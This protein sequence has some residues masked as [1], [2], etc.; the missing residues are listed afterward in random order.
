MGDD[1]Q[2]SQ[3]PTSKLSRAESATS[4]RSEMPEAEQVGEAMLQRVGPSSTDLAQ[5]LVATDSAT[6]SRMVNS[7]QQARGNG[8]VQRMI[9]QVQRAPGKTFD[10]TEDAEVQGR[11]SSDSLSVKE[12]GDWRQT[13]IYGKWTMRAK[14]ALATKDMAS[15][16]KGL[17]DWIRRYEAHERWKANKKGDEPPDPGEAPAEL[18]AALVPQK[19]K[20]KDA[21]P[22]LA[23][24]PSPTY[25]SVHEY[26]VKLP[27]GKSYTYTDKP[28]RA[29]NPYLINDTGVGRGGRV[30]GK[31]KDID[32]IFDAAG[33]IDATVRKVMKKVSTKEGG[34]EAINTYDTGFVSVGFIQFTTGKAG[35]GSLSGVLR[36]MKASAPKE[37]DTYFY[38]LGIDVDAKGLVVVAPSSGKQLRGQAA[39][40]AIMDDKR[41]TA[42]FQNAGTESRGFQAAQIVRAKAAYYRSDANFTVKSG[43]VTIS[44]QYA[45]VLKSE[46]GKVAIMDRTVQRGAGSSDTAFKKVCARL[47]KKHKLRTVED[48]AAHEREIISAIQNRIK[49]LTQADLTQP[50]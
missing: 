19:G 50:S 24:P 27:S 46:A 9:G 8:Y 26:K 37:F 36:E 15:T 1:R 43:K 33:I 3:R 40:Q 34:F 12:T 45:D 35:T 47:V 5:T 29:D 10:E 20:P 23:A 22:A 44:G 42:V 32:A 4:L 30:A 6:R 13:N 41:L 25:R 16:A 39:V 28:V 11:W 49:V 38:Q 2:R 21:W 17:K 48:L 31:R 7:L 14:A 18:T